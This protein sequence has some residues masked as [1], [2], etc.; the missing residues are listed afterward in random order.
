MHP[1]KFIW[2]LRA[3]L[4]KPFFKKIDM[5][6][7]IGKPI[8]I[9][10]RNR[11]SIGKK[12]RIFPDIRME[13]LPN[14]RILIEDNVYIGQNCHITSEDSE[15]R[16]GEGTAIMAGVCITN[17]DHN[18]EE[19]DVPILEQ[20]CTTRRTMIGK[21][22]FIGHGAVIQAGVELLDNVIVG[23]NSVVCRGGYPANC[24]IAGAP[25]KVIKKY[26]INLGEWEKL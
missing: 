23:A 2:S 8:F 25:A 21:N 13:A 18:Y 22:C 7:Y 16:I 17:I 6:T 1:I 20:G 15:L 24:V 4:Y 11:I 3:L 9:E 19:I 26:N 12:V 10:G 5:P 14:G